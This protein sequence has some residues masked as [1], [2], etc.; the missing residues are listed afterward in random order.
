MAN[1]PN[2]TDKSPST[3]SDEISALLSRLA[4]SSQDEKAKRSIRQK[5]RKLGHRGGLTGIKTHKVI[6][7]QPT[8]ATAPKLSLPDPKPAEKQKWDHVDGR[9]DRR[10]ADHSLWFQEYSAVKTDKDGIAVDVRTFGGE[11]GRAG[12]ELFQRANKWKGKVVKGRQIK[13]KRVGR[14]EKGS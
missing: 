1:A 4:E 9:G 6:E 2:P 8:P 12:A 11:D 5:L 7:G 14:I 10:K 3:N 13:G